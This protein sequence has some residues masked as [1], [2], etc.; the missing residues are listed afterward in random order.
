MLNTESLRTVITANRDDRDVMKLLSDLFDSFEKYHN[1]VV[2]E[3]TFLL[4]HSGSA[5]GEAFRETRKT[6]DA[7]RTA[8][9][10]SLLVSLRV[11]NR[12]AD[13]EG[14]PPV[15]AGIVSEEQPYRRQ[16]ADAVFAFLAD[17]IERR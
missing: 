11:L 16:A 2:K 4:L 8:C 15:Y 9:H 12:L 7:E 6:L 3:R 1:A 17:V 14:A 10:N 5:E 13:A